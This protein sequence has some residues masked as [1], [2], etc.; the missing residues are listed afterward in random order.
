MV[1]PAAD[2]IP[3]P[4]TI[5]PTGLASMST[6]NSNAIAS[7]TVVDP[8][9]ASTDRSL[10]VASSADS[11]SYST[12]FR[13]ISGASSTDSPSSAKSNTPGSNPLFSPPLL[14]GTRRLL[15]DCKTVYVQSGRAARHTTSVTTERTKAVAEE[16]IQRT[17]PAK[18][19]ITKIRGELLAARN[20]KDFEEI[21][22]KYTNDPN[23]LFHIPKDFAIAM[24]KRMNRSKLLQ[25]EPKANV[26]D[27]QKGLDYI[28]S[29]ISIFDEELDEEILRIVDRFCDA[30][31]RSLSD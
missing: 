21:V 17:T 3:S 18:P 28:R 10:S 6:S 11:P 1:S 29:E 12:L 23:L 4:I 14:T 7:P 27:L 5:E 13:S 20:E 15:S 22:Q 2:R 19:D 8:S 9:P 25:W 24:Q 16:L 30:L 26:C 31:S